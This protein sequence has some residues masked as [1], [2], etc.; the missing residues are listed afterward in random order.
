MDNNQPSFMDSLHVSSESI[1]GPFFMIVT[2]LANVGKTGL[3]LSA[4]DPFFVSLESG[5]DWIPAP[6]FVDGNKK[7][8]IPK[9]VDQFFDMLKWLLNKNNRERLDKPVKTVVIDSL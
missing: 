5:T 8:I 7:P 2:G 9:N 1:K 6:K 4:P 3:C